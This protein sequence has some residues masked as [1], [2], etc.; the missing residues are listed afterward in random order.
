MSKPEAYCT[1]SEPISWKKTT[2]GVVD[3]LSPSSNLF[4]MLTEIML[5]DVS[6]FYTDVLKTETT[7]CSI[8]CEWYTEF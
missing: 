7:L 1:V 8:I 5:A 4:H 6:N 3:C 2:E